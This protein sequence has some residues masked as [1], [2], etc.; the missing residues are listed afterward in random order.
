LAKKS[1]VVV[2]CRILRF[3]GGFSETS[4][5]DG[6]FLWFCDGKTRGE[7]GQETVTLM[8]EKFQPFF[9]TIFSADFELRVGMSLP[10]CAPTIGRR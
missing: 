10:G 2:S 9:S 4:G 6:G 1:I 5:L 3:A 7:D 8:G